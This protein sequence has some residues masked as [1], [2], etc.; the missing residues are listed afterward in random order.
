MSRI[1]L[2]CSACGN[3][4]EMDHDDDDAIPLNVVKIIHNECPECNA[5]NGGYG[6]EDM[7]DA[8]GNRVYPT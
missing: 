8:D 5:A 6:T 3:E 1:S 2:H 4:M 7:Y